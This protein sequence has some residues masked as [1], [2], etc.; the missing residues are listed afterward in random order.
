MTLETKITKYII[1]EAAR[2]WTEEISDTDVIIVGAGPAGMT[3]AKYLAEKGYKTVVF[4]RRL[5]FGGGIGGGGMLFHKVVT[6]ERARDILE[7]MGIK[8][9]EVENGFYVVDSTELIAK[10]ATSAIDAGAKI[11]LGVHVEDVIYKEN[12]LR[13]T[14]VAI[15]WSAVML[16]GLHVDPIFVECKALVDATGHDA[17][18]LRVAARKIPELEIK[19]PGEKSAYAELSEKLVVEKTGRIA[20]GLYAAGM[21]VAAV[22]GLPRMGPIFTGMLLSGKKVAE[23]IDKDINPSI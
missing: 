11:I 10:L 21:A 5:S 18:V 22:Y 6:D 2:D 19:I 3:A 1:K 8:A 15:Q 13:I 12:P 9:K 23:V 16:S 14:G 4:E 20:P 17:E 7:D